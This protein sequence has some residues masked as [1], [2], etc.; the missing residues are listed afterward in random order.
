M[1]NTFI[2]KL[3]FYKRP[4]FQFLLF[5]VVRFEK[6][7]C[8]DRAAALTY[9]TMLSLI[10][11]LTVFVVVLSTVPAF[12]PALSKIQNTLYSYLLP[13][14]STA[15]SQYLDEFADKSTS[16][17]AIG[18]IFLFVTSVMM[19]SS[20]EQAFN[21]IWN[22]NNL[23][24][25]AIGF[26]RSWMVISLG[27]LLMG[28]AFGLSSTITSIEFLNS[29]VAGYSIDW[30]VW[31]KL[32]SVGL[33]L[34]GFT[35]M[36]WMIPNRKVPFRNALL[37]GCM[38]GILFELLKSVFGF[39]MTHFTSYQVVYGAFAALP[40]F[41]LWIYLSW[42]IVLLGVEISYAITMF[43]DADTAPRHPVL[44]LLY[45]LHLF[46]VRQKTGTPVTESEMMS[47]L[48]KQEVE[49]WP[50]F[51]QILK[52]QSL[53]HKTDLGDYVLCRNLDQV[54]FWTFYQG[55]PYPLPRL[56]DL[57]NCNT[58]ASGDEW[59]MRIIPH[60][61]TSDTFLAKHL[62]IPLSQLLDVPP[63][64]RSPTD[65]PTNSPTNS[66]FKQVS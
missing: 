16:L 49:D 24:G 53:I 2:K 41:L 21:K 39:F 4:W 42:N 18:I 8:R 10:P 40:V 35:F 31:L 13:E 37:A 52:D 57:Q 33:T 14:S 47:L 45:I 15:V 34:F 44:S 60:L 23:R 46:Y 63:N 32:A 27:P 11:M 66:P 64:S 61:V 3:P 17:T 48:G 59:S 26:M 1:Y 51:T 43:R 62:S 5:V 29:N 54:D 56:E 7:S 9:T 12:S 65:N 25:G 36:Y 38:A 50:V 19:L 28:S 58:A 20:I 55:L 30:A 6:N 22:I